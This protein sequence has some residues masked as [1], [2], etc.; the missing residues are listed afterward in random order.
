MLLLIV[1]GSIGGAVTLI[2]LVFI[3]VYRVAKK[4]SRDKNSRYYNFKKK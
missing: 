2:V 3:V 4:R 1:G